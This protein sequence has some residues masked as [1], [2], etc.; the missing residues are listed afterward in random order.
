MA[1]PDYRAGY[2]GFSRTFCSNSATSAHSFRHASRSSIGSLATAS[3]S[4]M[5]A[6]SLSKSQCWR[7]FCGGKGVGQAPEKRGVAF[8][9]VLLEHG[10]VSLGVASSQRRSDP[11]NAS[12]PS[13]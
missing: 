13:C 7:F 10:R 12:R 9:L 5:L 4:R 11:V 2:L 1:R 8:G 3:L 6:K